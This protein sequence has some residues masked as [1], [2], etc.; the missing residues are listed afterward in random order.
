M[1]KI[2]RA[3]DDL[4]K[5][6]FI[7]VYDN[8]KREGETDL[9]MASQF[10]TPNSIRRMRKDGG[11]LIFLMTSYSVADKLGL[12]YLSNLFSDIHNKYPVLKELSP[13]DIPYDTKSS[14]SI[15]IN[16]R[17]TFTGI[18]D[19][20]RSLTMKRFA[21]LIKKIKDYNAAS[22]AKEFGREFRSPGHVPIC[23][24]SKHL[25][26]E[27]MGHTELAIALLEMADLIPAASGCEMLSDNGR[28]L[29]KKEAQE[30]AEK[31]NLVFLEGKEIVETWKKWSR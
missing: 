30:Y 23:I 28:A 3:L 8:D 26:N 7:L 17:N 14:F 21:E 11:G 2:D 1:E 19:I 27:R 31:Q 25:L 10:V 24:A 29:S 20:D 12:P 16:H 18:T 5:G 6:K 4:Q 22:A 15:Y 9:I 13:H